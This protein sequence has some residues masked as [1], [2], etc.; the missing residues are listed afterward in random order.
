MTDAERAAKRRQCASDFADT[1]LKAV[2]RGDLDR[3]SCSQILLN[4]AAITRTD[5]FN[6]I[7]ARMR[8][9]RG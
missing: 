6:E 9:A 2:A 5:H 7:L 8:E 3:E 1:L 4:Y